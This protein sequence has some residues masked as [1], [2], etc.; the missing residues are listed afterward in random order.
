MLRGW[1]MRRRLGGLRLVHRRV[2][3]CIGSTLGMQLL[4][5]ELCTEVV[6]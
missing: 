1:L 5:G 6:E 2:L 4:V 3:R